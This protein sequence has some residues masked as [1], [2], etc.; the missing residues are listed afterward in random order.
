MRKRILS[1]VLV[2]WLIL[3]MSSAAYATSAYNFDFVNVKTYLEDTDVSIAQKDHYEGIAT[4]IHYEYGSTTYYFDFTQFPY[5]FRNEFTNLYQ[6][7]MYWLSTMHVPADSGFLTVDSQAPA[8]K[9]MAVL[10]CKFRKGTWRVNI[11]DT[12]TNSGPFNSSP[13][14]YYVDLIAIYS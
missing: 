3:S 6:N 11:G 1:F 9:Y 8:A 4:L 12:P 13:I 5:N 14:T 7:T 2:F 10:S